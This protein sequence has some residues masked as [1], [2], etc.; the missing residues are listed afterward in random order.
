VCVIVGLMV[1]GVVGYFFFVLCVGV[2]VFVGN[3]FEIVVLWVN[4]D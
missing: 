3:K 4:E 2:L 1:V